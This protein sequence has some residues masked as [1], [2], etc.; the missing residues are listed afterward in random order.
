MTDTAFALVI[1]L[2][3][4]FSTAAFAVVIRREQHAHWLSRA[5]LRKEREDNRILR[6]RLS[7]TEAERDWLKQMVERSAENAS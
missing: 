4:L 5:F 6:Q 1:S 7:T 3:M 2:V